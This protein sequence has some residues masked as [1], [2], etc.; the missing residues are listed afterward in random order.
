MN[1]GMLQSFLED[2]APE[3]ASRFEVTEL[4]GRGTFGLVV[5]ARDQELQRE[6]VIKLLRTEHN[7]DPTLVARFR[8]EAEAMARLT[9]PRLIPVLDHGLSGSCYYL[10]APDLGGTSL[11]AELLD[12]TPVAPEE[13]I[14]ILTE[15]LEGLEALHGAGLVHR[16]LKPQNI[17]R[18]EDG[19]LALI[20][21]GLAGVVGRGGTLTQ[22]EELLGTPAYMAPE[23]IQSGFPV[24]S[25]DLYS[26][27]VMAYEMLTGTN[28]FVAPEMG[29][30]VQRHLTHQPDPPRKLREEIPGKLSTWVLDLLEKSPDDRPPT[31]T[32]ALAELRR[33]RK[34]RASRRPARHH[35]P[36]RA[37]GS[38]TR[39]PAAAL[40]TLAV[41]CAATWWATRPRPPPPPLPEP[42]PSPPPTH[43]SGPT[44]STELPSLA[45]RELARGLDTRL[46][47][48][49]LLRADPA[50]WG[51]IL[52]HLTVPSHFYSW[53]ADGGRPEDLPVETRR[54]LEAV[55]SSYRANGLPPPF[56]PFLAGATAEASE[57]DRERW[58]PA[59]VS[60]PKYLDAYPMRGWVAEAHRAALLLRSRTQGLE[61]AMGRA[62]RDGD[63]AAGPRGFLG[64]WRLL[65]FA[66]TQ[67]VPERILGALF[68][69][70]TGGEPARR[71]VVDWLGDG[72]EELR[73]LS[74]CLARAVRDQPEDSDAAALLHAWWS[75]SFRI[76]LRSHSA[77][78]PPHFTL[79]FVPEEPGG[80]TLAVTFL[81]HA[82]DTRI[83]LLEQEIPGE[84]PSHLELA[85]VPHGDTDL[86]RRRLATA[87]KLGLL[88]LG[89]VGNSTQAV[90]DLAE[91]RAHAEN[92]LAVLAGVRSPHLAG[93]AEVV[94][95]TYAKVFRIAS[96]EDRARARRDLQALAPL[97]LDVAPHVEDRL[98]A[99][100]AVGDPQ[101]S[102]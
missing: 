19:H 94:V 54:E 32:A 70:Y 2:L 75:E 1:S 81:R 38:R 24:V 15:I 92:G 12:T 3:F 53:L 10:I 41:L 5:K 44:L 89:S 71:A 27:G 14:A 101:E 90:V 83:Q 46:R 100:L 74:Y 57:L 86:A 29:K 51:Q 50:A 69:F 22:T 11:A 61:E 26:V 60:L 52:H 58:E 77:H 78:A 96:S 93:F 55:D 80:A 4:L 47:V 82:L 45:G 21:L 88:G 20:D 65:T 43:S 79:G 9:H 73:R 34:R 42:S 63:E 68:R 30:T 102:R 31:A 39:Y 98:R 37:P 72:P 8:R 66:R 99:A 17:L 18:L 33:I 28:P 59:F 6:V 87:A 40:G 56:G 25:S 91:L 49:P 23:A 85:M 48:E 76:Y 7:E 62:I 84:L 95:Q 36:R 13:A 64:S 67:P 35:D 16:D 97:V